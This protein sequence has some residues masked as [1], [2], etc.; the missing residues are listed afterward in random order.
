MF[1]RIS[2][3]ILTNIA[4]LA[5][6]ALVLNLL[7]VDRMVMD[8]AGEYALNY[9]GLFTFCAIFGFGGAFVSLFL[10]KWM[11]KRATRT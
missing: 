9:T 6:A 10:S 3:L 8:A 4:V 5:V 7:G 11:A 1:T 2:L